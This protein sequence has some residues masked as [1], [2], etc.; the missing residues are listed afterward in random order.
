MY[1]SDLASHLS[2]PTSPFKRSTT[3]QTNLAECPDLKQRFAL[4]NNARVGALHRQFPLE[5]IPQQNQNAST[6]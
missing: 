6:A 4:R 3:C 5:C 2:K 1:P